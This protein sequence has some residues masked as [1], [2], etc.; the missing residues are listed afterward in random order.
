MGNGILAAKLHAAP[1]QWFTDH[2]RARLEE[3]VPV[4]KEEP[5]GSALFPIAAGCL[6]RGATQETLPPTEQVRRLMA[7]L[8]RP[9][10]EHAA[11][12]RCA[13][14][15]TTQPPHAGVVWDLGSDDGAAGAAGAGHG[16]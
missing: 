14:L 8:P 10:G 6:C 3:V 16:F 2:L 13:R 11:R 1:T 4:L 12:V 7:M 15:T 9:H 5:L